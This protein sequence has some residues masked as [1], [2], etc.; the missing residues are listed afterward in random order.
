MFKKYLRAADGPRGQRTCQIQNKGKS[1]YFLLSLQGQV[2]LRLQQAL[3]CLK[4]CV[5]GKQAPASCVVYM[6][7]ERLAESSYLFP[8]FSPLPSS[9]PSLKE[10]KVLMEYYISSLSS[11]PSPVCVLVV[12]SS[13][14]FST[15]RV[16]KSERTEMYC[17]CPSVLGV[18]SALC[19]APLWVRTAL[20]SLVLFSL[21]SQRGSLG[22]RVRT[23]VIFVQEKEPGNSSVLFTLDGPPVF[24]C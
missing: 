23:L 11:S 15:G 17:P 21:F 4:L 5:N 8:L 3:P 18:N 9:T 13:S 24:S 14:Y 22:S 6:L 20:G 10:E 16:G 19:S 12:K 7:G 2:V 1:S